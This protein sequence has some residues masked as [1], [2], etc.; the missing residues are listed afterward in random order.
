M[1]WVHGLC[2]QWQQG[3]IPLG[4]LSVSKMT[5]QSVPP[6]WKAEVLISTMAE[7]FWGSRGGEA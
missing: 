7:G 2:G 6:A 4:F 1:T 3:S 5:A